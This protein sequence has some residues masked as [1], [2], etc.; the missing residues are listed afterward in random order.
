VT[1]D[2]SV[3]DMAG[4]TLSSPY[5]LAFSTSGASSAKVVYLPLLRK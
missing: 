2:T 4:N 5:Q 3:S 1:V